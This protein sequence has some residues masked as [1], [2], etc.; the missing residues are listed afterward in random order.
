VPGDNR[1]TSAKDPTN[2]RTTAI[3]RRLRSIDSEG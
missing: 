2:S 3:A 1:P